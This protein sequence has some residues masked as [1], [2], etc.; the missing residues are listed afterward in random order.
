MKAVLAALGCLPF[1]ELVIV[2]TLIAL[3]LAGH[4]AVE[5]SRSEREFMDSVE[6]DVNKPAALSH[7]IVDDPLLFLEQPDCSLAGSK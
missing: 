4:D 1:A 7:P 2:V 3:P 6:A 5:S